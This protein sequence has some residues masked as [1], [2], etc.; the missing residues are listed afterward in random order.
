MFDSVLDAVVSVLNAEGVPAVRKFPGCILNR[1]TVA[2]A[3][4]LKSGSLTASGCGN[5]LGVCH[6]GGIIKELYGTRA[7][8]KISIEIYTPAADK[9]G[10]GEC[11]RLL[12]SI[13]SCVG[14]IQGIKLKGIESRETVYDTE[15]EMFR[16]DC[17][18]ELTAFLVRESDECGGF[19]DFVLRGELK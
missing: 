7:E 19:T 3:V 18:A 15:A 16:C 17:T 14:D 1:N 8:L 6:D 11:M 13:C 4:S 10:E 12:E 5:Y 9:H 2:V